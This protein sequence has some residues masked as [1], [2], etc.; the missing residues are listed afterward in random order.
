MRVGFDHE[1]I[2]LAAEHVAQR[3]PR[4]M[5][6]LSDTMAKF[7]ENNVKTHDEIANFLSKQINQRPEAKVKETPRAL[8]YAQ[9]EFNEDDYIFDDLGRMLGENKP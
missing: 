7:V 4:N 9:R 3:G 6:A 5:K 1:S 8:K 2:K